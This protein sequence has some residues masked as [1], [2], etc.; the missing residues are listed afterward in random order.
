MRAVRTRSR[1][2]RPALALASLLVAVAALSRCSGRSNC[3]SMRENA[4]RVKDDLRGCDPASPD[5]SPC[6]VVAGVGSDCTGVFACAFAVARARAA[7]AEERA[8]GLASDTADCHLCAQPD[9]LEPQGAYCDPYL[10]RCELV[11]GALDASTSG[12]AGTGGL[13]GAGGAA[14]TGG[15]GSGGSAGTGGATDDSGSSFPGDAAAE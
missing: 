2:P 1:V 5:P 4:E 8:L 11:T 13:G 14:G 3:D 12:S 7:E 10:R 6:V 9:C 15:A